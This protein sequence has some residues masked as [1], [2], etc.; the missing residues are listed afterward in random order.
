MSRSRSR[1]TGVSTSRGRSLGGSSR[2]GRILTRGVTEDVVIVAA[3]FGDAGLEGADVL[4][5]GETVDAAV[6]VVLLWGSVLAAV[7]HRVGHVAADDGGAGEVC[8][9]DLPD[10]AATAGSVGCAD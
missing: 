2:G 5:L 4:A 3:F 6:I 10:A 7:V 8:C 1:R 9:W